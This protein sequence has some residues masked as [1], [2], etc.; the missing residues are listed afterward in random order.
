MSIELFLILTDMLTSLKVF[1]GGIKFISVITV[2]ICGGALTILFTHST[3]FKLD[4]EDVRHELT[5]RCSSIIKYAVIA[6]FIAATLVILIPREKTLYIVAG[7][8]VAK[9]IT[10]KLS[11][12]GLY[13]KAMRLLEKRIDEALSD[14]P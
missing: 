13:N 5:S 10:S 11:D 12:N 7:V 8:S 14:T 3:C 1:A 4:E 9:D 2:I 6:Y